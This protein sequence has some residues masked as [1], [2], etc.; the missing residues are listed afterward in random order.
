VLKKFIESITM[1]IAS[2]C[3]VIFISSSVLLAYS[4]IF[5]QLK[6]NTSFPGLILASVIVA[7]WC[8]HDCV[9]ASNK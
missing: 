3:V 2:F 5:E 1:F 8:T 9:L 4:F 6:N 7:A